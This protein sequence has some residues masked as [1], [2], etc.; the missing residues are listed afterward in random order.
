MVYYP[1]KLVSDLT[2]LLSYLLSQIHSLTP[3]SNKHTVVIFLSYYYSIP[4]YGAPTPIVQVAY[5]PGLDPEEKNITTV[6][7]GAGSA[8]S[9]VA[10]SNANVWVTGEMSH[11]EVLA[12]VASGH[13]VILCTSLHLS[14]SHLLASLSIFDRKNDY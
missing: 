7:L 9:L 1:F 10:S 6:A 4:V 3:T 2:F 5:P 11:H 12:A 8:G 14:T 13:V